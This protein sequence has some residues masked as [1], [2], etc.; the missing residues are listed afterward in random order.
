[1]ERVK[2]WKPSESEIKEAKK[3]PIWEKDKSTFDWF[4][5]EDEKFYLLEGEVE[6]E[7]PDGT[8]VRFGQGDMVWF[9]SG[10]ECKWNILKKVRK[11]YKLG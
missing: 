4:Y 3:W 9:K 5:D 6:V 8:N 1:M 2:I 7:L 10:T 11:H